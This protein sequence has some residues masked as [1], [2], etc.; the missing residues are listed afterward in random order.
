MSKIT[1]NIDGFDE[2][3]AAV[4]RA[5]GNVEKA[6]EECA[7]RSAR[8]L[9]SNLKREAEASGA[10]TSEVRTEIK[11]DALKLRANVGWKLGS[12]DSKN[13]SQGYRAM[14]VEYGTG[15]FSDRGK[16][17][18]RQTAAGYNR[19]STLPHPFMNNARKK[20]EKP[21]HAIQEEMLQNIAKEFEG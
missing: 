10:D 2:L 3:L 15:K 9:E 1:L 13:P 12:Y 7:R 21:I 6:A 5:Q 14:F 17:K 11:H 8:V 4:K 16:G 18:D 19:G 20:S